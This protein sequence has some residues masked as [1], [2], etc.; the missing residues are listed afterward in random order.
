MPPFLISLL[1]KSPS[2]LQAN[3]SYLSILFF[4]LKNCT[5]YFSILF[6]AQQRYHCISCCPQDKQLVD[7]SFGVSPAGR[8]C[9]KRRS[10]SSFF[11]PGYAA[12][13][14]SWH[15]SC[16]WRLPESEARLLGRVCSA[17]GV[18]RSSLLGSLTVEHKGVS[19]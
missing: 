19:A 4:S 18:R 13:V 3:K 5:Y 9:A 7:L 11:R 10:S 12:T 6:M 16:P 1:L 8:P 2:F 14:C 17:A 15:L